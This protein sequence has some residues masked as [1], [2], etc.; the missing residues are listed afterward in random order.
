MGSITNSLAQDLLDHV[1]NKVTYTNP[2]AIYLCLC[3]ADPTDAAT[4]ASMNEVPN[5]YAYQ[6]TAV[7]LG[8]AGGG[9]VIDQVGSV[10][11]P[12][13]SGGAWGDATHWAIVDNQTYGTGQA[14]AFG[15]LNATKSIADGDT[16]TVAASEVDV[17]VSAGEVSNYLASTLL[18]FAFRDQA[19]VSPTVY[20]GFTDA[21][22][23][24]GTTGATASEPSGGSYA[25]KL[26][27]E[28]GGG[29]PD[30]SLAT[31]AS[32]SV[33]DNTDEVALAPATASWSTLT[34]WFLADSITTGAGNILFY[35]NDVTDKPVGDGDTAK[36]NANALICQ[37]S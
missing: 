7:V 31:L 28:N 29:T 33:V 36:F 18:D 15:A 32:P 34:S 11:F 27:Y 4:G 26:I 9:R 24:D 23:A 3:T 13:A 21:V 22:I 25:R 30:F 6:R 1:L 19:F 2:A 35:D 20:V 12:T 17:T 14:M 5:L 16:P 8:S 10:D 37:M